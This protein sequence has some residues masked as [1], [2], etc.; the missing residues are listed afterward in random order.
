MSA[1]SSPRPGDVIRP[2]A[3]SG[4]YIERSEERIAEVGGRVGRQERWLVY[5]ADGSGFIVDADTDTEDGNRVWRE[6]KN[7]YGGPETARGV[8]RSGRP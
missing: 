3:Y 8:F 1:D 7:S 6:I 4:Q 5:T 2:H